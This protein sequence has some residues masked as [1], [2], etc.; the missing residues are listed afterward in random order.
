[1]ETTS[2]PFLL[3]ATI[4][5]NLSMYPITEVITDQDQ[6]MYVDNWLSG[7]DSADEAC[8]KYCE[9]C[10]VLSHAGMPLTKWVYND[11]THFHI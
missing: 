3:N 7:V 4:K 8:K 2:S 11:D 9:A 5:N 6:D 1:M 10:T